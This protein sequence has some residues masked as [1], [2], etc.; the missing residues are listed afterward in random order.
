MVR[1]ATISIHQK[2][3]FILNN[4]INID[5]K[6]QTDNGNQLSNPNPTPSNPN[7][8]PIVAP[9]KWIIRV[10]LTDDC[11]QDAIPTSVSPTPERKKKPL[12]SCKVINRPSD[13]QNKLNKILNGYP[14]LYHDSEMDINGPLNF[15][16]K[17]VTYEMK[18]SV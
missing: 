11:D 14:S 15:I 3:F 9:P 8:I 18:I 6:T 17:K 12:C 4:S 2:W 5:D 10:N 1:N 16:N 13:K 7:T